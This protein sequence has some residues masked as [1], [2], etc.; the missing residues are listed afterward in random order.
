MEILSAGGRE[1]VQDK[2]LKK[3]FRAAIQGRQL[4]VK[5]TPNKNAFL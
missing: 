4:G 1:G 2:L 3:A 5:E